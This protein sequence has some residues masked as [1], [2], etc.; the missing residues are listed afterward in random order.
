MNLTP[1]DEMIMS[2]PIWTRLLPALI[3]G[4]L[5]CWGVWSTRERMR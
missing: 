2:W 1:I 5:L 3:A 4:S